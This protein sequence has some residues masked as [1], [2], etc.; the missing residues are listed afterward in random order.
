M[1]TKMILF[2]IV[3]GVSLLFSCKKTETHESED[4]NFAHQ[5]KLDSLINGTKNLGSKDLNEALIRQL[6]YQKKMKLGDNFGVVIPKRILTESINGFSE[7]GINIPKD[8]SNYS[9]W[10]FLVVY[11]GLA[12]NESN[13]EKLDPVV[14]FYKGGLDASGSFVP[15]GNPISGIK[16][17][18]GGGGDG[19][20]P[21]PTPPP[22]VP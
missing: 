7:M 11:S 9:M 1:K 16:F 8:T 21:R 20:L 22:T 12:L 5:A 18:G 13:E 10:D 3:T 15:V 17:S 14:F 2:S 6:Q 19:V 4:V